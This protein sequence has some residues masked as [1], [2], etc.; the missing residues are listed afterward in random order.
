LSLKQFLFSKNITLHAPPPLPLPLIMLP[1]TSSFFQRLKGSRFLSAKEA[2]AKMVEILNSRKENGEPYMK[3]SSWIQER[4]MGRA[5]EMKPE[6]IYDTQG[7]DRADQILYH[8]PR[9]K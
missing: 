8:Y 1:A 6:I 4:K 7:M 5:K 9:Y 3:K 2:K